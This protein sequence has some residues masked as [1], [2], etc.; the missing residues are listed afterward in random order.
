MNLL[1]RRNLKKQVKNNSVWKIV[2]TFHFWINGCSDLII[3]ANSQ[4][5][6]SNFKSFFTITQTFLSHSRSEQF[7]KKIPFLSFVS[8]GV[9]METACKLNFL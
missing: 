6:A 1:D 4:P 5:L 2:Q 8:G 3:F 7:W 9:E